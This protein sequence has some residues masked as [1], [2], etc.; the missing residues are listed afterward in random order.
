MTTMNTTNLV[1]PLLLSACG[2]MLGSSYRVD[3]TDTDRSLEASLQ[4]IQVL[5]ESGEFQLADNAEANNR[6]QLAYLQEHA[7]NDPILVTYPRRLAAIK[8]KYTPDVYAAKHQ[9][10]V[11]AKAAAEQVRKR[12]RAELADR[13]GLVESEDADSGCSILLP[14][15]ARRFHQGSY[16]FQVNNKYG[17]AHVAPM[18]LSTLDEL[19]RFATLTGTRKI[20][21]AKQVD[22]ALVVIKATEDDGTPS[23]DVF[24]AVDGCYAKCS[25]PPADTTVLAVCTSLASTHTQVAW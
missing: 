14:K 21:D 13:L 23:Q 11:E 5:R 25:G 3:T 7:P 12:T 4:Q 22:G 18:K 17:E 15:K 2:S 9:R 1:L 16:S 6:V 20:E 19:Q 24:V 8:D 10:D